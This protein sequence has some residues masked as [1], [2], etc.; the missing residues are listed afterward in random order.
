MIAQEFT[1][2]YFLTASEGNPEQEMPLPL[3]MNR[4]IEVSTLH[5]NTL[6]IGF[7]KL[8]E[9]NNSWVLTRVTTEM[10]RYPK[11]N[12]NYS[13][14]TWI[15]DYNRH[16][17]LRNMEI[18]DKDGIIIGYARTVWMVISYETRQSADLTK[19]DYMKEI[20]ADKDCPIEPQSH[21]R[22]AN[23]KSEN[24]TFKY[25][26]CDLNRHVNTVR[27]LELFLNQFS[28]EK[29][30]ENFISRMEIAFVKET[31]FGETLQINLDDSNPMDCKLSLDNGKNCHCRARFL[32][33]RR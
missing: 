6:G 21:L 30:D 24:Y 10:K 33:N 25:V 23:G 2:P 16:F 1:Q 28:L 15:E 11:I 20:I 26:D 27:Y 29:Y 13:I 17:S 14:T 12:E 19:L 7:A 3:L 5:A 31:R 22:T 9:N 18:K 32:F 8:I 4:L